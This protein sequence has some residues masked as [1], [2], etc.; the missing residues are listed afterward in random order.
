[1]SVGEKDPR[2]RSQF[3]SEVMSMLPEE[4]REDILLVRIGSGRVDW[5]KIAAY[6]QHAEAVLYPGVSSDSAA[7]RLRRW[8]LVA[9]CSPPTYP[10]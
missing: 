8:H 10:P 7:R 2:W 9:R 4:V 6:F 3:V 5:E 1:M